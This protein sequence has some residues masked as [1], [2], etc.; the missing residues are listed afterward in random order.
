MQVRT[1]KLKRHFFKK[2]LSE[3][4]RGGKKIML[5]PSTSRRTAPGFSPLRLCSSARGSRGVPA[6]DSDKL[7]RGQT[8]SLESSFITT[9]WTIQNPWT[10]TDKI[11]QKSLLHSDT[12]RLWTILLKTTIILQKSCCSVLPATQ[13]APLLHPGSSQGMC[14]HLVSY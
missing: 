14:P 5:I 13:M 12:C 2:D 9:S 6:S 3:G 11:G 10:Y 4:N 7:E 8:S 1:V